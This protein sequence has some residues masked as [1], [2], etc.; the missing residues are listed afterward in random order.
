M[1]I[2]AHYASMIAEIRREDE[3]LT[4]WERKFIFGSDDSKPIGERE[5]LTSNQKSIIERIYR[6]KV[7]GE[8]RTTVETIAFNCARVR[9]IK[10]P[11]GGGFRMVVDN[12]QVGPNQT[13]KECQAVCCWLSD[14]INKG[15]IT[16]VLGAPGD[17]EVAK[18]EGFPGE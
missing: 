16:V 17:K 1:A 11:D 15:N 6:E 10:N 4:D 12:Q 5:S 13:L 2:E 9:G 3:K 14:A 7:Q 18:E 8:E